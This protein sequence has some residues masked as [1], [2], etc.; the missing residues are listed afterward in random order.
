M[1]ARQGGIQAGVCDAGQ[2]AGRGAE[3]GCEMGKSGK[4][5]GQPGRGIESHG[6]LV[7]FAGARFREFQGN[8]YFCT[9][10]SI[11]LLIPVFLLTACGSSL[12]KGPIQVSEGITLMEGY[13]GGSLSFA[14]DEMKEAKLK[15]GKKLLDYVNPDYRDTSLNIYAGTKVRRI[16]FDN[17][18]GSR[19]Y[20]MKILREGSV[21]QECD[22]PEFAESKSGGGGTYIPGMPGQAP[23]YIPGKA[24]KEIKPIHDIR[25][26]LKGKLD[27]V[28]LELF[29]PDGLY[30]KYRVVP[31]R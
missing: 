2:G 14:Q 28:N 26:I 18:Q 11:L 29:D 6:P 5:Q 8:A 10:K 20:L 4:S 9:M 3:S 27:T 19:V 30:A 23:M 7:G 12:V 25:C 15:E 24:E 31:G 22:E 1:G 16:Y 21:V 17:G 13:R